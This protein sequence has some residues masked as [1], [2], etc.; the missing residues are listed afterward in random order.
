MCAV[1]IV[2]YQCNIQRCVNSY[3]VPICHCNYTH[4]QNI[5][6]CCWQ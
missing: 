4:K 3:S 2:R 6:L 1:I 5:S